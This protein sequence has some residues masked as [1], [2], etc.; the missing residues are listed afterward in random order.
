MFLPISFTG[1]KLM[2]FVDLALWLQLVSTVVTI[3]TLTIFNGWIYNGTVSGK[4]GGKRSV[5]ECRSL[6]RLVLVTT[7]SPLWV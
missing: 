6:Q 3:N 5:E 2:A 4:E 1:L 7:G